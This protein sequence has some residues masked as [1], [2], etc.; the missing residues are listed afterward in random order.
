MEEYKFF[1]LIRIAV[2]KLQSFKETPSAEE[3]GQLFI[4]AKEQSLVGVLSEAFEK[5]PRSQKPPQNILLEWIGLRIQ[6]GETNKILNQYA[7]ELTEKLEEHRFNCCILKG[8]GTALYYPKPELRESGD[9]DIWIEGNRKEVLHFLA[10]QYGLGKQGWHHTAFEYKS[11]EVEVHHHPSKMYNF[12][13]NKKL[14]RF[15]SEQW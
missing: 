1:E 8:Q 10:K 14:Q 4:L 13:K 5:L 7:R 6:I 15:Y 2:G 9:I 12:F 3:W 11:V